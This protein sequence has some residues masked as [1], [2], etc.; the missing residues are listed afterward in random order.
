MP[1]ARKGGLHEVGGGKR[2]RERLGDKGKNRSDRT[3]YAEL[4][5]SI[6][7]LP[8]EER[9]AEMKKFKEQRVRRVKD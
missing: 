1:E 5:D 8:K 7:D 9:L 4:L 6:K 2:N 3:P